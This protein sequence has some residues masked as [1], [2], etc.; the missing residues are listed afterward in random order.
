MAVG[1]ARLPTNSRATNEIDR[2][3]GTRVR[4]R[5]LEIDMS[6]ERLADILG[7]TFQQVQKY[8]KGINRISAVR[9]IDICDAMECTIHSLYDGLTRT[10]KASTPSLA[11]RALATSEGRALLAL[12]VEIKDHRVRKRLLDL[13]RALVHDG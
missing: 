4:A 12:F 8:E 3:L 5:R 7:I 9:L 13:A 11:E 6:Q 2:R 1:M 10:S